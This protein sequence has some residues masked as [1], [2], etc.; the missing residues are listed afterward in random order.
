MMFVMMFVGSEWEHHIPM[1]AIVKQMTTELPVFVVA[2]SRTFF[3]LCMLLPWLYRTGMPGI[4]TARI[5]RH[6][7]RSFLGIS[8]GQKGM[9]Y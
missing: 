1:F 2:I 9:M 7:I 8:G 4:R 3:A 5:G 6:F